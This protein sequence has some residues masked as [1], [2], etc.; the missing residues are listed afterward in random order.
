MFSKIVKT[1]FKAIFWVL[2]F[3]LKFQRYAFIWPPSVADL[4]VFC[5]TKNQMYKDNEKASS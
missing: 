3:Y 1:A 2:F 4:W 5:F